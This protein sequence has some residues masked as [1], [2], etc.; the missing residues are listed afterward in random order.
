MF[1]A[2]LPC[3]DVMFCADAVQVLDT[4]FNFKKNFRC[5]NFRFRGYLLT[6]GAD[7]ENILKI[8]RGIH[9]GG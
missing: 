6:C 1:D 9:V 2:N 4:G 8:V 3:I 5:F 7:F